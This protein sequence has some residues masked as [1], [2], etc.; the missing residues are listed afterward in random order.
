MAV[1]SRLGICTGA[2]HIST[3]SRIRAGVTAIAEGSSTVPTLACV[4]VAADR[5][6][7]RRAGLR[8]VVWIACSKENSFW[9]DCRGFTCFF[10]F[11]AGGLDSYDTFCDS[12]L[13]REGEG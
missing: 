1:A 2:I 4:N 7:I 5:I 13:G 11:R 10:I 3:D 9:A 12:D 6:E 8:S